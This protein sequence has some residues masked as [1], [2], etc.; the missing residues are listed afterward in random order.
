MKQASTNWLAIFLVLLLGAILMA[1]VW[2]DLIYYALVAIT[3]VLYLFLKRCNI[4]SDVP[5]GA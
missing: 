3:I 2:F 4:D 1:G 5:P